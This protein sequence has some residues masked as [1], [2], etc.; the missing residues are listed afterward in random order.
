MP[1][2][3]KVPRF[4]PAVVP[5]LGG[6]PIHA[7]LAGEFSPNGCRGQMCRSVG[8]LEPEF[9]CFWRQNTAFGPKNDRPGRLSSDFATVI[10][11]GLSGK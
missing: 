4:R 6:V 1:E 5:S 8:L 10:I 3:K 7:G 2:E 9:P 11:A